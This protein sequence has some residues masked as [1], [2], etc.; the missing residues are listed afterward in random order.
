MGVT[1][2][3]L[4]KVLSFAFF[5]RCWAN[6]PGTEAGKVSLFI[7]P[8]M[9]GVTP[10]PWE[11]PAEFGGVVVEMLRVVDLWQRAEVFPAYQPLSGG[12]CGRQP[13]NSRYGGRHG[14]RDFFF[15]FRRALR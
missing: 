15:M 2:L 3:R 11:V 1:Q 8:P 6:A 12:L 4:L 7:D 13:D 10:V 5:V 14:L 9:P